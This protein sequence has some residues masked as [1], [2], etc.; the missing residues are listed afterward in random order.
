MPELKHLEQ[1]ITSKVKLQLNIRAL[2]K[3]LNEEKLKLRNIK[4][5]IR[6]L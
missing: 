2:T 6:G 3:R 1:L 4:R 5:Q